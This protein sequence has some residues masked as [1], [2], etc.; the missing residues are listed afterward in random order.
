MITGAF[1]ATQSFAAPEYVKNLKPATHIVEASPLHP[2]VLNSREVRRIS[3]GL[4][5]YLGGE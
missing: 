4:G 3:E 1:H 2:D 5:P